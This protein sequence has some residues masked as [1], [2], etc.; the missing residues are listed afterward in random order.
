M[1]YIDVVNQYSENNQFEYDHKK[2]FNQV[3][4]AMEKSGAERS[5]ALIE[6]LKTNYLTDVK[7][8][9]V[10]RRNAVLAAMNEEG[11]GLGA[12]TNHFATMAKAP[13]FL[14]EYVHIINCMAEEVDSSYEP[15]FMLG[16]KAEETKEL[17]KAHVNAY[18]QYEYLKQSLLTDDWEISKGI[19]E[20]A[21]ISSFTGNPIKYN[22]ATDDQKLRIRE[23]YIHAEIV[24]QELKNMGFFRK[25]FS[26]LGR[27]MRDYLKTA[28]NSLKAVEFPKKAEDA[29]K[30][31]FE[32][33]MMPDSD[34]NTILNYVDEKYSRFAR[35]ENTVQAT[36]AEK[37]AD[38][39]ADKA[40][41]EEK[42]SKEKVKDDVKKASR[43]EE[44]KKKEKK[45]NKLTVEE[46]TERLRKEEKARE[47]E[48]KQAATEGMK[49]IENLQKPQT[50]R[51]ATALMKNSKKDVTNVFAVYFLNAGVKRE[52]ALS[53]ATRIFDL[54]QK[55]VHGTWS[56]TNQ[57]EMMNFSRDM[58]KDIYK[59]VNYG[60]PSMD[61]KDKLIISQ[62][63]SDLLLSN[64]SSIV[65]NESCKKY[66]EGYAIETIDSRDMK[67]L[68]DYQSDIDE[69]MTD[70]KS[71]FK[72]RV[73]FPPD[74]FEEKTSDVV[75]K[76]EEIKPVSK[77]LEV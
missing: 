16:M 73:K 12:A 18:T 25:Y 28:E 15:T 60:M 1:S 40:L 14:E 11:K 35:G 23:T 38:K 69:L 56:T 33:S 57:Y 21:K 17:A 74:T 72:T 68:T 32:R 43:K 26:T 53:E 8:Y 50:V 66:G 31:E 37:K 6:V 51:A 39:N 47:D 34:A 61:I 58:F 7:K 24:K 62:K 59:N 4:K 42:Q 52:A 46:E 5:E 49:K 44:K 30:R 65:T 27:T 29:T 9:E 63:M 2:I 36:E 64:F 48:L 76:V 10:M 22:S 41:S 55:R 75:E 3:K 71:E 19:A 77:N 13:E 54:M 67:E 70:V 20:R 45:E